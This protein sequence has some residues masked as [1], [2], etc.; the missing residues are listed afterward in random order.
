MNHI[1]EYS[2]DWVE[3]YAAIAR[4]LAAYLPRDCQIHHV[5][6]TAIP[7]MPAKDIIDV[8]IECPQGS[9]R[10][11]IGRLSEAGYEHRGDRGIPT[12]EAF[13]PQEGSRASLLHAHHLYACESGSPE[14]GRHLAFRDYLASHP[15]RARRLGAAKRAADAASP[16]RAAYIVAKAAAYKAVVAEAMTWFERNESVIG[17]RSIR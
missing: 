13:R 12:R 15:N 9:M 2:K 7:N 10:C 14:L 6:S 11:V 16:T 3:R 5:G 4:F 17:V 8:D 1:Q